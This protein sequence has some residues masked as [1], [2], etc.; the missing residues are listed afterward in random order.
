MTGT[1]RETAFFGK[2]LPLFDGWQYSSY[3]RAI[4][5]SL[6][7]MDTS[8]P[9]SLPELARLIRPWAFGA[10]MVVA[11][12]FH[13]FL[14]HGVMGWPLALFAII[15]TGG[16]ILITQEVQGLRNRWALLFLIPLLSACVSATLYSSDVIKGVAF[17]TI[18]GSLAAL[19]Y[20]LTAPPVKWREGIPLWKTNVFLE[21]ALPFRQ[22]QMLF[23][24]SGGNR[25]INSKLLLQIGM[26]LIIAGPILLIFL[27]L[28]LEG[29]RYFNEVVGNWITLDFLSENVV[30]LFFDVLVGFFAIGFFWT[31]ARRSREEPV[32]KEP[33]TPF[34]EIIATRSFLCAISALFIV[35]A[36]FQ[37]YYLFQGSTYLLAQGRT[38]ADYAVSGYQ[39]LCFAA[40]FAFLILLV[41]Y[42]LTDMEDVWVRRTSQVIAITS[43]ISTLSA[44]KRLWL[45]VDAYGLTLSRSW[46]MQFLVLIVLLF[47]LLIV[48]IVRRWNVYQLTSAGSALALGLLSL[49]ILFNQESF[50]TRYNVA[51]YAETKGPALDVHYLVTQLSTD[52]I[53]ALAEALQNPQWT[54]ERTNY[55]YYSESFGTRPSDTREQVYAYWKE[56]T[57][58]HIKDTEM[59]QLTLS[60]LQAERIIEALSSVK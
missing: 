28:F 35:F 18:A 42:R 23:T 29:D 3:S 54:N 41:I 44:G 33:K 43:M 9:R 38:Y 13:F 8:T 10:A 30:R 11:L 27:A 22:Y 14:S 53:P 26:G 59:R 32:I 37:L 1:I 31:I 48:S 21:A 50:V 40:A 2:P 15:V 34:Q 51:R 36:A 5:R 24:E 49:T 25:R 55:T 46:G 7:T 17:F 56:I 57:L 20:W 19:A 4:P 16:I 6:S 45:Y 39:Q 47:I 52:A 60:D 58:P 12:G